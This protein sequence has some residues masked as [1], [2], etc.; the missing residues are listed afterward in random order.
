MEKP[1]LQKK[2]IEEIRP[3]LMKEFSFTNVMQVPKLEKIVLNVGVKEAVEDS[4]ALQAVVDGITKISGQKP[5]KTFAKK[6]IAGFKIREGMPI[7]VKVTLRKEKMYD[8][9]DKF[10]NLALPAVRDFQGVKPGFDG[11]G[12]Y[13]MGIK[14]WTIFPE[15]EFGAFDKVYGLNITI[16]TSAKS[17]EHVL[18]LLKKFNMPFRKDSKN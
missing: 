15:I 10:I 17:D 16:Q 2:Y 12:N 14:E 8:F 7:G 5:I 18:E 6:S 11:R 13:N 4:K 3:Q 9:L 1:R